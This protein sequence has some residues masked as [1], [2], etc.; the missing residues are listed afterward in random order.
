MN[1]FIPGIGQ[2][3]FRAFREA[4]YSYVDK[5]WLIGDMLADS[6]LVFLFPRPRR[7]G[8]TI[9]LSMLRYFLGKSRE[10]LSSLFQGLA[11]TRD[12]QA[13]KHFQRYPIISVSFKDVKATT[14]PAVMTGIREQMV[15]AF[16]EHRWLLDEGKLEPSMADAF[17]KVLSRTV[18]DHELPYAFKWLSQALYSHYGERVVILTDEYDTPVQSGHLYEFFD[19][20]VLFFR[21]FFSACLKDNPALFKGVLTGILRVSGSIQAPATLSNTLPQNEAWA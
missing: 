9:T 10:D 7:F 12:E 19:D 18:T 6:S 14:L 2:S 1:K 11:V 20:V 8:K 15:A 13:M 21:N 5:S 16:A 3:D 4:G 17:Q